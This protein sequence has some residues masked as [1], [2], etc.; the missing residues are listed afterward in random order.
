MH[1][2]GKFIKKVGCTEYDGG[3]IAFYNIYNTKKLFYEKLQDIMEKLCIDKVIR[4]FYRAYI[5]N[6]N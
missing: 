2:D 6:E 4:L 1:H 3:G 5:F